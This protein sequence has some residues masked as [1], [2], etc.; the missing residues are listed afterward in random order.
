[1]VSHIRPYQTKKGDP[2]AFAT[3]EDLGGNIDLVVF[4]GSWKKYRELIEMDKIIMVE[5][6]VDANSAEPKIL[7]D[8][9]TTELRHVTPLEEIPD[10]SRSSHDQIPSFNDDLA[11]ESFD[12]E[13]ESGSGFDD[14]LTNNYSDDPVDF[15][16][17]PPPDAFAPGWEDME[18]D[19][20]TEPAKPNPS[21]KDNSPPPDGDNSPVVEEPAE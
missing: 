5:G 2:M 7:V 4:P 18:P 14:N 6:R 13:N 3:I 15:D 12:D 1:M 11:E 21:D 19:F 20:S 17:P 8:T 9:V 16:G 10:I